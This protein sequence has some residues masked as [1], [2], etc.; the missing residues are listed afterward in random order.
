MDY[1]FFIILKF[2]EV[3]YFFSKSMHLL[4]KDI[5]ICFL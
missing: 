5:V 1:L 2:F 3:Y 4:A